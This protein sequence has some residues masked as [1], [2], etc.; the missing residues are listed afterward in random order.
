MPKLSSRMKALVTENMRSII[1]QT[2]EN[3]IIRDGLDGLSIK[4]MAKEAEIS[5]GSVYNYFKNKDEIV[6]GIL[7]RTFE[8]L[9]RNL[10][11]IS[12][13]DLSAAEKLYKMAY[14]MFDDFPRVR[15]LYEALMHS[16]P[17]KK[18]E[19]GKNSFIELVNLYSKT[20]E[21]GVADGEFY[22]NNSKFSALAFMGIIREL[23]M[24]PGGLFFE[25]KPE[26]LA[27][28]V[29]EIFLEG[30]RSNNER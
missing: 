12:E 4:Q 29:L 24:N 11:S 19:K 20:I 21:Q 14:F 15:K 9:M 17:Q 8:N 18:K 6:D 1:L 22:V 27:D 3:I 13:Q 5:A 23:Q 28:K 7:R 16:P 2:S 30:I 26:F 25:E 10:K